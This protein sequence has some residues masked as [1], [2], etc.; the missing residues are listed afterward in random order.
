VKLYPAD[1]EAL[2]VIKLWIESN[3]S[4]MYSLKKLCIQSGM[5]QD[6]LKKGFRI[7]FGSPVY[8]YHVLVKMEEAKRLL[9]ESFEPVSQIGFGLGYEHASSFCNE[10]K[11]IT[12]ESPAKFRNRMQA[13]LFVSDSRE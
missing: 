2:H 9:Q 10:F 7:L 1:R 13:H 4:E 3:P 5:N 11:K 12:G 8:Q 6:K